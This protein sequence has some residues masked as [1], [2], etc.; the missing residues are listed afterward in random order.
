MQE[1]AGEPTGAAEV[2]AGGEE[3]QPERGVPA[4]VRQA[5]RQ[6]PVLRLE[7]PAG[8]GRPAQ[9]GQNNIFTIYHLPSFI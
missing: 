6:P 8:Q 4:A 2:P 9:P 1:G 5:L 3:E 7:R